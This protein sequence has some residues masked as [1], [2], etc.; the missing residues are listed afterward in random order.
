MGAVHS[1]AHDG[2]SFEILKSLIALILGVV[3]GPLIAA[4]TIGAAQRLASPVGAALSSRRIGICYALNACGAC[5]GRLELAATVS[6]YVVFEIAAVVL[7]FALAA[8]GGE[9][10]LFGLATAA[11]TG[12]IVR[13]VDAPE[14]APYFT[15]TTGNAGLIDALVLRVGT[16]GAS[17][18]RIVVL[19]SVVGGRR[20]AFLRI[21]AGLV[22]GGRI[23]GR[24]GGGGSVGVLGHGD[25]LSR[26]QAGRT[27]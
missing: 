21:R 22:A 19:R 25:V 6:D 26:G 16:S 20:R 10:A 11:D 24:T 18:A 3:A 27:E 13:V 8:R 2:L 14:I 15:A 4:T 12:R 9:E 5:A 17:L 1:L 7:S 23:D